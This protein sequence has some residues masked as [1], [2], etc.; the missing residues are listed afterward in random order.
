MDIVFVSIS[1]FL[2]CILTF[3]QFRLGTI[4]APSIGHFLSRIGH[5]YD[6]SSPFFNNIY[7]LFLVGKYAD[8]MV[9]VRFGIPAVIAAFLGSWLLIPSLIS[10]HY[11]N[12]PFSIPNLQS[13]QV[14]LIIAVLLIIFA[15]MDLLPQNGQNSIWP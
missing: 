3:S 14:G 11:F 9:L 5:S 6:R 8:K 7:K 12:I 10:N 13:F 2:A 1:T 15:I 4:L